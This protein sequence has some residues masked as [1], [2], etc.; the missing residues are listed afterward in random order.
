MK[1]NL[2]LAAFGFLFAASA[3]A[4]IPKGSIFIGGQI[5]GGKSRI[6]AWIKAIFLLRLPLV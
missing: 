1:K 4:Q 5:S 2:L 6:Q 3:N